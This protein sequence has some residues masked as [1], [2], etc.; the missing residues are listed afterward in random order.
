MAGRDGPPWVSVP[1]RLDRRL[2]LGP[3]ESGRAAVKFVTAAAVGA[4]VSLAVEPW[5]GLPIVVGGAVVAL[6]R[7]EGEGLDD[8]L[9]SV[10]RW[11]LR[12]SS[13]DR[14]MTALPGP[15]TPGAHSRLRLPNGRDAVVLR[16]AGVPVAFLPP[17]ELAR[18]FDLYRELLRSVAGGIIVVATSAPIYPDAVLPSALPVAEDERPARDGYQELV[19]LLARRRSVRRVLWVLAQDLPGVEGARRLEAAAGLL[20]ERLADLGLRSERLRD[21]ALSEAGRRLGLLEGGTVR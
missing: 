15:G 17:A 16:T 12:R 7:P 4:V 9:L 8:R 14:R 5:A 10:A 13:P 6:W 2:R 1:E 19:S 3:F 11:T 21:R 20:R 18:Q